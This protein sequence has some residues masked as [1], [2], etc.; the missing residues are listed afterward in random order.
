MNREQ[1]ATMW[2]DSVTLQAQVAMMM[3]LQQ[4]KAATIAIGVPRQYLY[5]MLNHDYHDQ[6]T[7]HPSKSG[8]TTI[9]LT[10]WVMPKDDKLMAN[11]K[12]STCFVLGF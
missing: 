7:P 9:P 11:V 8:E 10:P 3:Q 5:T 1:V 6:V 2:K 4:V 12:L